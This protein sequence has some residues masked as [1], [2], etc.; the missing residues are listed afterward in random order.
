M[1]VLKSLGL[2]VLCLWLL[3]AG[4]IRDY[5]QQNIELSRKVTGKTIG[6]L[7]P[8]LFSNREAQEAA[9]SEEAL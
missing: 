9:T 6:T 7:G 3:S 4:V 8:D 5:R 2:L 1:H